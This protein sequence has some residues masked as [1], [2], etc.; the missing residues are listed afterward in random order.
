MANK[1]T[2]GPVSKKPVASTVSVSSPD[3]FTRVENFFGKNS[4]KIFWTIFGFSLL[5]AIGLFEMKIGLANDD[6][7]YIEAGNEYSKGFFSYFYKATAPLYSMVVGL[8]ITVFG[9]NLVILKFFSTIFFMVS[10]FLMYRVFRNRIPFAVLFTAMFIT[11]T[12][13]LFLIHAALTY[14]EC[15]FA[16]MQMFFMWTVFRLIDK[17]EQESFP[18]KSWLL[19][20]AACGLMYISRNV[21]T[22]APMAVVAYFLLYRKWKD[23]FLV[24]VFA[25][26]FV[27]L[28]ECIKL[29]IWDLEF[30]SQFQNQ[31]TMMVRKDIFNPADPNNTAEDSSGYFARLWGNTEVYIGGRFWEILG[32]A[33]ENGKM[34]PGTKTFLTFF[35]LLL[36]LPGFIFSFIRK[37]K[38]VL[39]AGLYFAA[40]S[41]ATYIG[42]HTY[43]AQAR[44]IM[45]YLPFIFI[46]IFYGFYE[47][48]KLKSL[49][50]FSFFWF[51]IVLIFMIPNVLQSM[52]KVPAN[53]KTLS[54]NAAGDEFYGYTPDWVNFFRASRYCARELPEGSYVASRRAPMSYVYGDFKEFYPVYSL[55]SNDPDSLLSRFEKSKVTHVLL[56][57]LRVNPSRYIPGRYINTLHRYVYAIAAKYPQAFELV[58]TE[59][60]IEKAEVYK[61]HYERA[62]PGMTNVPPPAP[63]QSNNASA[64]PVGNP[65][66]TNDKK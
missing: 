7:L 23:A 55:H 37:N 35:T 18:W 15:F 46:V 17:T 24:I 9:Y 58:H 65:P 27:F 29:L 54:R 53:L 57:E 63:V 66:P 36:M 4:T 40:L 13:Y 39:I 47:L 43:W 1:K 5:L 11:G 6:A 12:N 61:I 49:K 38:A 50:G 28:Y 22:A 14:T 51:V 64:P 26:L 2:T 62:V 33:K 31:G 34:E 3:L 20:G 52:G 8:L 19:F 45:V 32:L 48:F 10:L 21:A 16:M 41:G 30:F 42:I 44:L 60:T 59:G 56:A 25:L